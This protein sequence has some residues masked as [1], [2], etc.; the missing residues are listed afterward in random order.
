MNKARKRSQISA[1][2][3]VQKKAGTEP[4]RFRPAAGDDSIGDVEHLREVLGRRGTSGV[5][6]SLAVQNRPTRP[7]HLFAICIRGCH[8]QQN[9]ARRWS[10]KREGARLCFTLMA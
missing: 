9:V 2:G 5:Q 10:E 4:Q 7:H 1:F 8:G 3:L 6:W